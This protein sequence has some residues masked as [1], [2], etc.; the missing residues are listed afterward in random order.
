MKRLVI[1]LDKNGKVL[2]IFG[3][4]K[5]EILIFDN[6]EY[7]P[8]DSPKWDYV[9]EIISSVPFVLYATNKNGYSII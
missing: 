3:D 7:I 1:E 5:S 9:D 6:R 4:E 2:N 8:E